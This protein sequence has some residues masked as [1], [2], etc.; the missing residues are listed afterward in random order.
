MKKTDLPEGYVGM[1]TYKFR[2]HLTSCMEMLNNGQAKAIVIMRYDKPQAILFPMNK[3]KPKS[4][5]NVD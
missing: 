4:E 1:T 3:K 2:T 5:S